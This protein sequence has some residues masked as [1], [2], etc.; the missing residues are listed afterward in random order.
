MLGGVVLLARRLVVGALER[1]LVCG[2]VAMVALYVVACRFAVSHA[3]SEMARA[4]F[5]S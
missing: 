1:W 5:D 3:W 4:V 2:C